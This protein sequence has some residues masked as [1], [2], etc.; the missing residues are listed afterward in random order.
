MYVGVDY[1]PEHWP[2]ERWETRREADAGG[3][4]QRRAPGGVRLGQHGA[5][6]GPLRVRLARR[7]PGRSWRE[8]GISAILGTPTAAMPAWVARKY[9]E[10]LAMQAE[11]PAH[12][13][14]ACARTTASPRATYRLLSRAH[15][16]GDGR[17]LRPT[18]PNVIG[19]QTDNEFGAPDLL[20]RHLPRGVPGLAARAGT[21]RWTSST[22]AG[23]RTSGATATATGRR[24]S[25][26]RTCRPHNPSLCLDWQR[27]YLLAERPVPAR[28]RCASCAR[29]ARKHFVTHNFMG[30]FSDL[31]YYD[32]AEDLDFVSWDNYPVWGAP[33]I[34]YDAVG[35]ADVM[36][37]L[38]RKNFWIME[39]TA[40]PGGWGTFGR[41]P[42]PGEIR[43]IA[44]QQLAHGADGHDLVPLAHLHGRPRAVLARPAGA[45]RQ[46]AAP[47]PRGGP[48]GAG[49][50][51]ARRR[52]WRAPRCGRRGDHLR[53]RQHLGRCASSRASRATT[54]TTRMRALLRRAVPRG[55]ERGHGQADAGPFAVPARDRPGALRAARCGG[56]EASATTWRRAACC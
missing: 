16:P 15:H 45:R 13:P 22:G 8:R 9:P 56:G 23:A 55:R 18:T 42:R 52:T 39:Q 14:G 36:R 49:V 31:D 24:S 30:L 27:F 54:T 25:C 38:K 32:L 5:R 12:P 41:N 34:P 17:A 29:S 48:D 19:W 33:E 3:R 21:G 2:R 6:G 40:G 44:Y 28:T 51:P 43:K 47:L 53:L 20:L 26:R 10:T 11:R 35:R 1:Y 4:V 7:G 46:A 37:G 50:P